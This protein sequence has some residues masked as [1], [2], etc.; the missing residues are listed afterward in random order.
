MVSPILTSQNFD[1]EF[2]LQIYASGVFLR[3][4]SLFSPRALTTQVFTIFTM[5]DF[6]LKFPGMV[7]GQIWTLLWHGRKEED[8]KKMQALSSSKKF[9]KLIFKGTI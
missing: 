2:V 8:L 4:F 3:N 5:Y 9:R 7:N 6:F 1:K